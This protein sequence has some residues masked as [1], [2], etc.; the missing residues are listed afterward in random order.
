MLVSILDI[1]DNGPQFSKEVEILE[2]SEASTVGSLFQLP[3]A[4]DPDSPALSLKRYSLQSMDSENYNSTFT[5]VLHSLFQEKHNF[6]AHSEW[7]GGKSGE[8]RSLV[9]RLAEKLD[10]EKKSLYRLKLIATDGGEEVEREDREREEVEVRVVVADENDNAPSFEQQHVSRR[11]LENVPVG[12]LVLSL[13][14]TDDDVG[15]NG[16]VSYSITSQQPTPPPHFPP[17]FT[18]NSTTGELFVNSALDH[19]Q[20]A[21]FLLTVVASDAAVVAASA[22]AYVNVQVADV[23]DNQPHVHVDT[24]LDTPSLTEVTG[25]AVVAEVVEEAPAWVFVAQVKVEDSDSGVNGRCHCS[26]N[27]SLNFQ[28]VVLEEGEG[29]SEYQVVTGKTL[30]REKQDLHYVE[31]SCNDL[32]EPQLHVT[33]MLQVR[34]IDIND[35]VPTFAQT[36]HTLHVPENQA[37]DTHLFTLKAHDADEGLNGRLVYFILPQQ[38]HFNSIAM[39]SVDKMPH[40]TY[41]S[42]AFNAPSRSN[43]YKTSSNS[44]S[45][46][47]SDSSSNSSSDSSSNSRS[48][49]SSESSSDSSS[50]TANPRD[51][52]V[53]VNERTGEVRT[54]V[55]FDREAV[56][57]LHVVVAVRDSGD[58][59]LSSTAR[60]EVPGTP[61][62]F[63]RFHLHP[64]LIFFA[65]F[66]CFFNLQ[67]L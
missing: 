16:Q 26:L 55:S 37:V 13:L 41:H 10:R 32:G 2:V 23:N 11:L 12:T 1:N 61:I 20:T 48:D 65:I 60:L 5:I 67:S 44:S 47:S 8:N 21:V 18:I 54:A 64:H 62:K 45:R 43:V 27:D 15:I 14:A 34:L 58:L 35:H 51:V 22:T 36:S 6:E 53:H 46:S 56:Q 17:T 30:D 4:S 28:L 38:Q 29:W 19:E 49:S 39:S 40:Q 57:R 42:E 50:D 59:P 24:F 25:M 66:L 3:L 52:F 33:K 7:D 63:L 31:I 9:L